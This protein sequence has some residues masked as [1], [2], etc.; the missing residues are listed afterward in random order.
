MSW[1]TKLGVATSRPAA[2]VVFLAY[3]SC[4]LVLGN[5]L[6]WHSFA[7][8]ATWGMTLLIQRSEHRDTQAIHA[9]LDELLRAVGNADDDLMDVDKKDAEEVERERAHVQAS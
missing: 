5:G 1:L 9:K 7:T 4:W 8:L 6:D 3:G 2:F